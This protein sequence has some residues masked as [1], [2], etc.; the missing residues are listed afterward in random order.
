MAFNKIIIL[1][2]VLMSL[3]FYA[4]AVEPA[5]MGKAIVS[6]YEFQHPSPIFAENRRYMVSLPERYLMTQRQYPSLFVIDADFQFQHV[7]AMVKNLS[8]TGKIPPMIVIGIAN[9]G[10]D[11]YLKTTTWSR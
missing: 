1:L 11:D 7:A 9:Q 4:G 6:A 3:N 5:P 10:G 2:T 8:R